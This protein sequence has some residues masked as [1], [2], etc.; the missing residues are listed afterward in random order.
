MKDKETPKVQE[1]SQEALKTENIV[2]EEYKKKQEEAQKEAKE[3]YNKWLYLYADFENYK[4]RIV[5]EKADL[6]KYGNEVLAR[7]LLEVMDSLEKALSHATGSNDLK[8]FED[9]IRLTLKQFGTVLAKFGISSI[10]SMGK[11]FD[12][13]F[14]EAVLEKEKENVETGTVIEEHQK[15]YLYHDR[16]L[17]VAKVVVAKKKA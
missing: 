2:L 10:E 7:E 15:G 16:L 9:G 8:G 13:H 5:K 11:K 1:T 4:K 14:H 12:P 6:I 17:R 3:N